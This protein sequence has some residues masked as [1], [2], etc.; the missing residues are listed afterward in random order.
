MFLAAILVG[1]SLLGSIETS[2]S[3][4]YQETIYTTESAALKKIF[5]NMS[6][7]EKGSLV[8]TPAQKTA[9]EEELGWT[10]KESHYTYFTGTQKGEQTVAFVIDELGKHYPMTLMVAIKMKETCQV[11]NVVMMVYR[12]PVGAAVRKK[13]FLRQFITKT[14]H[15]P[16]AVDQ[17]IT[18][19][20]GATVSSWAVAAAVRKALILSQHLAQH[21]PV[22]LASTTPH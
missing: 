6:T 20:T 19:I 14:R 4:L 9:I 11:D 3:P 10:L 17:D 22:Q 5:T 21:H 15:H 2:A 18:G 16:I 7:I 12:E 13:R 1:L 8:L